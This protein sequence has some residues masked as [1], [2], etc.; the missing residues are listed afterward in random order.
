MDSMD[1]AVVGIRTLC[2]I[3]GSVAIK[4]TQLQSRDTQSRRVGASGLENRAIGRG[5]ATVRGMS[6]LGF[7]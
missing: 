2:I 1:K 5:P 4:E 3:L 7:L 6:V